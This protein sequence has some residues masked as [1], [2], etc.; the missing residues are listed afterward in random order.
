VRRSTLAVL[1]AMLLLA[2]CEAERRAGPE[3]ALVQLT[4]QGIRSHVRFLSHDLLEGRAPGTRGGRI[5]AEYIAAR[6]QA[7]GLETVDGSYFQS[8]PVVGTT[9][10]PGSPSLRFQRGGRTADPE[11]LADYVLWSGDPVAETS[12]AEGE[13]VFVGYGID[14][15]EADWNDFEGMDMEGKVLLVLVNDPGA[16]DEEPG[17]FEGEAMTY[18]GRWTYKYEEAARRGAAGAFIVHTTERAGYPWAVVRGSW[19]GE[20]FALPP[21]GSEAEGVPIEG[22]LTRETAAWVLGMA[23]LS[24]DELEERA[25]ER[26]FAPV[27]TGIRVEAGVRSEVR[28]LETQNV[29]GLLP[30]SQRAE[31]VVLLMA[32]YDHLG[33]GDPVNGDS[34]YNGAYDNASGVGLLLEQARAFAALDPAP[35][36]T[37]IFMATAAEESGLLGAQWY[38]NHPLYPLD[39]TAAALNV[40]GVN[41]WGPTEDMIAMGRERSELGAFVQARARHLGVELVPDPEPAAGFFFRSDHFPFARAG[42]PALWIRHGERFRDRPEGWGRAMLDRYTAEAYHTPRD[43]YSDDFV[44]DG[45]VQQGTLLFLTAYDIAQDNSFPNWYETSEFRAAR[46]RMM[47]RR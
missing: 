39:R 37:V 18:Y 8:V 27:A 45:A 6:F 4:E 7:A 22:W 11:Y 43:R 14:A 30:G 24:L 21:T 26:D 5:A 23:G 28:R 20:Q 29:V 42:V 9:P 31:E 3:A 36:R 38:V 17:R 19:S 12:S 41:L 2:A 15:P 40:D 33:V 35:A 44:F 10:V 13:L 47:G 32:H 34:I 1:P 46:D 16:T 25:G